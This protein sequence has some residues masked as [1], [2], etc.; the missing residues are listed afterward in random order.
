MK[1]SAIGLAGKLYLYG[2]PFVAFAL[3]GWVLLRLPLE[4][5]SLGLALQLLLF[6]LLTIGAGLSPIKLPRGGVMT[7]A[8]ALDY[9]GILIFG[10]PLAA[11]IAAVSA[12]FVLRKTT[13]FKVFWNIGQIIFS[14]L[15]A[16]YVYAWAGGDFIFR[17]STL[18]F[19]SVNF[20][21]LLGALVVSGITYVVVNTLAVA[22]AISVGTGRPLL[23]IWMVSF[24][25]MAVRFLAVAPFGILMAMVFQIKEEAL[26]VVVLILFFVPLVLARWAFKGS[27]GMLE[28]YN[29]TI[30]ALSNALEAYDPYTRNHSERVTLLAE[31]I[32]R[33]MHLP[34]PKIEALVAAARLHDMGKCRYDWETIIRKP[35]RPSEEEWQVIRSHPLD[36]AQIA[37]EIQVPFLPSI[38]DIVRSHHE[39]VDGSGYP[40]G[41]KGEEIDITGRVLCVADAFEAIT[42]RRSYQNRRSPEE[43]LAELARNSGRQFDPKV[44][45]AVAALVAEGPETLAFLEVNETAAA[46]AEA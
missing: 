8:F 37:S 1:T 16:G 29:Q 4:K 40:T 43:A 39:R 46:E 21:H 35:G 12:P 25:W 42:S 26:K 27:M 34:E 31:K 32:A 20:L 33:Q 30:H 15:A 2:S 14:V 23:G 6:L 22:G 9:A 3:W 36:G 28:V 10:P 24:R 13:P 7:V 41:A 38:A 17:Q 19:T 5:I 18:A 44:V 11:A 45:E